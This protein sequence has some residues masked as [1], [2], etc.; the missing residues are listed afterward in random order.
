MKEEWKPDPPKAVSDKESGKL[1]LSHLAIPAVLNSDIRKHLQAE[2][3]S[4]PPSN[5][6]PEPDLLPATC[7]CKAGWKKYDE[8]FC[9]GVY[10]TTTFVSKVKVFQRKCCTNKCSWHFDGQSVGVFNYSG[11]TLV[12]YTL[13]WDFYH[14]GV[15]HGMSWSSFLNKTND[16]Y[17]EIY[18]MEGSPF[19]AMSM[20][21]FTK[22]CLCIGFWP[23]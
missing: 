3:A 14:C 7:V 8:F 22:V 12:S 11:E 18:S 17:K 15:K 2:Q 5:F 13:M 16:M 4:S 10:F 1:P 21:T 19:V 9:E 20:N 23:N 6:H